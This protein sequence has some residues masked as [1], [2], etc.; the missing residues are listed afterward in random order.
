MTTT[1]IA[2]IIAITANT[3]AKVAVMTEDHNTDSR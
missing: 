2:A 3:A 1:E